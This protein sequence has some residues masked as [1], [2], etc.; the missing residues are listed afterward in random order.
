M[1]AQALTAAKV[2]DDFL[3]QAY[4]FSELT[5]DPRMVVVS[6][7]GSNHTEPTEPPC[8]VS[9]FPF[10]DKT[11]EQCFQLLQ[12]HVKIHDSDINTDYF[13]VLDAQ[14]ARVSTV[15]VVDADEKGAISVRVRFQHTAM[16]ISTLNVGNLTVEEAA[17][18]AATQSDG[19]YPVA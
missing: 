8:S 12:E 9:S 18:E 7:L 10:E 14:S 13:V 11:M 16:L 6:D 19:V 17:E 2:V 1:Q 4:N 5:K 15:A 3:H